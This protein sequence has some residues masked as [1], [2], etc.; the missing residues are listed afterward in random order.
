MAADIK[1]IR[2]AEMSI[3]VDDGSVRVPIKNLY[4]DEIGVFYFRPTDLGIIDR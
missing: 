4:G 2:P 3:T 1:Q